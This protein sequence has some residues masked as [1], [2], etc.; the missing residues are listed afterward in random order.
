M[1]KKE[2]NV[3]S[4]KDKREL[5]CI[6]IWIIEQIETDS[7]SLLNSGIMDY[8]RL[9]KLLKEIGKKYTSFIKERN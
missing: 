9:E 1:Y 6:T 7:K 2:V 3:Y 4:S 5:A 8:E